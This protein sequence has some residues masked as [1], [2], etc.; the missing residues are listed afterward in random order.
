[1][2]SK[3]IASAVGLHNRNVSQYGIPYY[4]YYQHLLVE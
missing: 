4:A 2:R 1:M 3:R